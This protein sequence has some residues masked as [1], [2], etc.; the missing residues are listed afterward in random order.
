MRLKQT[1]QGPSA[2]HRRPRRRRFSRPLAVATLLALLMGFGVYRVGGAFGLACAAGASPLALD[3]AA[4]PAIAP[5]VARA[6]ARATAGHAKAAGRCLEI[7]VRA[8]PPADVADLLAG[9]AAA[10]PGTARPDVWIPDTGL[11]TGLLPADRRGALVPTGAHVA[12]SPLVAAL[13]RRLAD[14]AAEAP[15]WTAMMRAAAGGSLR[16]RVPDPARTGPGLAALVIAATLTGDGTG[17]RALFSAVARAW[18]ERQAPSVRAALVGDRRDPTFALVPEQAV[19]AH[20]RDAPGDPA[21]TVRPAEGTLAMDYPVL[22]VAPAAGRPDTAP[23]VRRLVR[24]LASAATRRDVRNAGFRAPSAGGLRLL[25]A[26]GPDRVAAAAQSWARLTLGIRLLSV[27]DVSGSMAEEI[28]PGRTRLQGTLTAMQNV[29]ALFPDDSEVGLW[30]FSAAPAGRPDFTELVGVGPLGERFGSATRRQ[31]GLNAFGRLKV[32][33]HGRTALYATLL[34]AY[35]RMQRTYKPE[36]VNT[37]AFWTDGRDEDPGG[38]TLAATLDALRGLADPAR[39]VQVMMFA[40]GPGA[41][42]TALGR[43]ARVVQGRT[44]QAGSPAR[45]QEVFGQAVARRLCAPRCR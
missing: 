35:A 38:P 39:P 2:R 5:V 24:A 28:A 30:S 33:P 17:E 42:V 43:I 4:E 26:P 20:N 27:V 44:F 3:V 6:A 37:I 36:F 22:R 8:V 23:A 10:G 29:L 18:R 13:P 41:D 21:V 19:L 40:I 12:A 14:R 34:A 32:R 25:A 9:R 45:M 15:S 1:P 16:M 7:R 31:L 11:W